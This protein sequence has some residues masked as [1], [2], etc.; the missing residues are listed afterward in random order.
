MAS[1]WYPVLKCIWPQHVCAYGKST[2]T[3][4]FSRTSTVAQPVSGKSVSLK[5]VIKSATRTATFPRL[6]RV[7]E[8]HNRPFRTLAALSPR[9]G[10]RS[11]GSDGPRAGLSRDPCG[12]TGVMTASVV[13]ACSRSRHARIGSIK[14]GS[15]ARG[16]R[17]LR[18]VPLRL[19][20]RAGR[21]F[22]GRP[23]ARGQRTDHNR[24]GPC[25]ETAALQ[26]GRREGYEGRG[27]R[28]RARAGPYDDCLGIRNERVGAEDRGW[29]G[30]GSSR[31]RGRGVG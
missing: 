27:R 21:R 18:A 20:R 22:A 3:P 17:G 19:L 7:Q 26:G 23:S 4:R 12:D 2:S 5:Q 25:L 28:W 29:G 31:D 10:P 9:Q 13:I 30:S 14:P 1:L 24:V 16:G 11:R 8:P 15:L 6:L